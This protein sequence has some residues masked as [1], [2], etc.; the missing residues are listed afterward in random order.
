[1]VSEISIGFL[2]G[3][4]TGPVFLL[5][6]RNAVRL[7]SSDT[8]TLLTM[9]AELL[10]I[11]SFWFTGSWLSGERVETLLLDPYAAALAITF[12]LFVLYPLGRMALWFGE[13]LGRDPVQVTD[14]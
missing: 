2:I 5:L 3:I 11:P 1:M 14:E 9:A 7:P 8:A 10:S 12:G 13:E 4:I 6:I